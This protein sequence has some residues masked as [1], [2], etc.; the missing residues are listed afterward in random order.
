MV[1]EAATEGALQLTTCSILEERNPSP[2]R[3]VQH[4]I[5]ADVRLHAV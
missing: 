4:L 2:S 1:N 5:H 3:L